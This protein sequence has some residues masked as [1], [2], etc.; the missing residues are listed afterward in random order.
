[1]SET[2]PL[3]AAVQGSLESS[4]GSSTSHQCIQHVRTITRYP[5]DAFPLTRVSKRPSKQGRQWK[6]TLADSR[7]VSTTI[8]PFK[9]CKSFLELEAGRSSERAEGDE[10]KAR[11]RGGGVRE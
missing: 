3:A 7:V 9:C 2:L 5:R 1:M 10:A 8:K 11:G 4:D 6:E